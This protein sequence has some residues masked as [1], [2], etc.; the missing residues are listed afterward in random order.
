MKAAKPEIEK[1][2][3]ALLAA[4]YDLADRPAA[5]V[6]MSRGKP[7]QEGVRARLPA[8]VTWDKLAAMSP[9]GHPGPGPLV[10]ARPLSSTDRF[11]D[12]MRHRRCGRF[13][14]WHECCGVLQEA[15]NH[16]RKQCRVPFRHGRARRFRRR[17]DT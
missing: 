3:A 14:L 17:E 13:L 9:E 10:P 8:G 4:R 11:L 12:R 16:E 15:R 7:V 2:Q 6:K 1:R 5:G